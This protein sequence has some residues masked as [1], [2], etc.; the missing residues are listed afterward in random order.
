[1]S[2][3][4]ECPLCQRAHLPPRFPSERGVTWSDGCGCSDLGSC[5]YHLNHLSDAPDR[6][7]KE[8]MAARAQVRFERE[9]EDHAELKVRFQQWAEQQDELVRLRALVAQLQAPKES[10]P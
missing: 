1:M 10:K 9:C 8:V 2:R 6:P 7:A 4:I 3:S 5:L